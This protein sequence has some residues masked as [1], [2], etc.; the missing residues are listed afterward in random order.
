MYTKGGDYCKGWVYNPATKA[1]TGPTPASRRNT[2]LAA[3]GMEALA[4]AA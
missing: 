2:W 3:G 4:G 1:G